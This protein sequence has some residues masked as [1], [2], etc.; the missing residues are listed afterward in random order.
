MDNP[1]LYHLEIMPQYL[2]IDG[3]AINLSWKIYKNDKIAHLAKKAELDIWNY[4]KDNMVVLEPKS[5]MFWDFEFRGKISADSTSLLLD[6]NLI[7][8]PVEVNI[9]EDLIVLPNVRKFNKHAVKL[10]FIVTFTSFIYPQPW[11]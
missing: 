5:Q 8:H 4:L 10:G 9:R 1:D 3:N 11:S 6:A 7:E 2:D